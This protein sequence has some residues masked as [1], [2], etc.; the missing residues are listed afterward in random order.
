YVKSNRYYDEHQNPYDKLEDDDL[1]QWYYEYEGEH[2]SASERYLRVMDRTSYMR[3]HNGG[4]SDIVHWENRMADQSASHTHMATLISLN[5]AIT[6]WAID[7]A[8]KGYNL[9]ISRSSVDE[10]RNQ[11][12]K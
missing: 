6:L 11:M 7:M 8:R 2:S 1:F 3:I 10:S 5:K 9:P 4:V 12:R